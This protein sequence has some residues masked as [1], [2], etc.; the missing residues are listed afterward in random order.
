MGLKEND[1]KGARRVL[2]KKIA[3]VLAPFSILILTITLLRKTSRRDVVYGRA[4]HRSTDVINPMMREDNLRKK[5][6]EMHDRHE[7][8]D[9]H[10]EKLL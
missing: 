3:T 2:L 10:I 7:E 4:E 6:H 1:G 5:I 8:L 9:D